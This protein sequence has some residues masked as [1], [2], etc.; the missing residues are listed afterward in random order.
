M[1]MTADFPLEEA[2]A[3]WQRNRPAWH[4]FFATIIE[5]PTP[6]AEHAITAYLH[7]HQNDLPPTLWIE[8]E[9]RR[10]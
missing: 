10:L 3:V 1:A 9:R 4:Q 5:R 7:R 8:L 6:R 2:S